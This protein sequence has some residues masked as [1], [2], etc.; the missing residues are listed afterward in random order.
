MSKYKYIFDKQKA[1]LNQWQLIDV[2]NEDSEIDNDLYCYWLGN[3][4]PSFSMFYDEQKDIIR[5]KTKYEKYIWK[6]YELQDGEYIED[7][8]IKYKEKP[9]QDEWFWYWKDFEWQFDFIEWKK[10]LE[11]KL[12]EIR[13]NAMHKDI[14]YNNFVFRMLPVDVDNFKERALQVA[15]G[16]TQLNDITEWRL[17]NDEVHNFTI[18]EILNILGMW[19]KRKVDIFEKFNKLYVDFLMEI[20]EDKIREFIKEVEE[21]WK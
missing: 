20:E 17:K 10:S 13:N 5:E 8:E 15:L 3:E 2:K 1:K 7:K 4:Y 6:E 12:F 19:G 18:K 21:E 9:K 16:M 11:Q 14:K